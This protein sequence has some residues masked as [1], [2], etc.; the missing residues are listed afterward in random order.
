MESL[1]NQEL[2]VEKPPSISSLKQNDHDLQVTAK[3]TKLLSV[4]LE[5][6][7]W[8]Q[9]LS[10]QLNSTFIFGIILVYGLSQGFSGSFSKV[11]TDYYW[12]DVQ[13]VQPSVVQIYIGL[14]Y[15]PSVMKPIWGLFTDAFPIKGYHRR[16]Y[17]VIA[18][19]AGCVSALMFSLLGKLPIAIA[20]ACSVGISAGIAI[21]DVVIDACIARNSIEIR[22]LAPDMQS[23]CGFC[24]AAGSLIGYAV[25]GFSVNHLGPQ[26]A[27]GVLAIPPVLLIVLGFVIYETRSANIRS[28]KKK[29]MENVEFTTK[30][31][32]KSMKCPQVWKPSLYMYLSLAVSIS[33]HEG[34]FYWYTDPKAGPAFSQEFV[35]LI[36]ALG[37][38]ASM[39]GV[40][41]YHKTLKDYPLRNLLFSAQLLYGISGMLDL[42]FILRWNLALGIPDSFFVIT[43]QCVSHIISKI[44]WIPMIVLSTRLCPIGIEGT[45]FAL[46]MCIDSIGS[47]TSKWGGGIVL[48]LL[49]VTRTD[50]TNLWLVILIRNVLRLATLGLIFLVPKADQSDELIPVDLL[51]KNSDTSTDDEGLQLVTINEKN[52]EVA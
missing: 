42:I 46:L 48:H 44:R 18:G 12:K 22:A 35:G 29:V 25:S 1:E 20:L 52:Q 3:R 33:T 39:I 32:Y 8:L 21:A 49:H 40:L 6:F 15:L 47:L 17:F 27:L 45:F 41:I 30:G 50:F 11:V 5:P 2:I 14:C 13:K 38:V 4:F 10:S 23:L 7:Q 9:M 43:E 31:M 36:Y 37:A 34:Q 16:P 28:E 26:G 24:S 19:V 51:R